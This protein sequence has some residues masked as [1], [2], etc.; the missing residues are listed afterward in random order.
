[1]RG[2]CGEVAGE[3][4]EGRTGCVC[5][6]GRRGVMQQQAARGLAY[7]HL[8]PPLVAVFAMYAGWMW[9]H[10][11]VLFE[12]AVRVRAGVGRPLL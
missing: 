4:G 12:R 9:V 6:W 11:G 5:E 3:A 1:M 2:R 10:I 7:R 8:R